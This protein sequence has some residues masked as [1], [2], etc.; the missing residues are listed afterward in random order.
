MGVPL[1]HFCGL[2]PQNFANRQKAS[3]I[4]SKIACRCVAKIVE[5]ELLNPSSLQRRTPW[6]AKVDRLIFINATWE[7]EPGSGLGLQAIKQLCAALFQ[8]LQGRGGE[9]DGASFV[10]FGLG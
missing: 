6:F 8:Q 9:Q 3:T 2:V 5:P 10:V 1:S 4:H 7:N